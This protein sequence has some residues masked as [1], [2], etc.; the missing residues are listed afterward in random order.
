LGHWERAEFFYRSY[1]RNNPGARNRELVLGLIDKMVAKEKEAPAP[2]ATPAPAAPEVV[3]VEAPTPVQAQAPPAAQA[4]PLPTAPTTATPV[5]AP[6]AAVGEV[7]L[8]EATAPSNRSHVWPW[9]LGA[10]AVLFTGAAVWGWYEA[11][12]FDSYKASAHT[13]PQLTSQQSLATAGEVTGIAGAVVAAALLSGA[14]LT[15]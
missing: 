1:L 15:W 10:G 4:P 12:T 5:P 8:D 11:A 13:L 7:H 3:V 2:V 9:V 14:V 6:S